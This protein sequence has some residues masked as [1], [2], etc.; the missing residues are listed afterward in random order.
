MA[1]NDDTWVEELE[2]LLDVE[3]GLSDWEVNFV[4]DVSKK[5][6][7]VHYVPSELMKNKIKTLWDKHF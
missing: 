1:A 4:D 6:K 7:D 2:D 5:L 3:S